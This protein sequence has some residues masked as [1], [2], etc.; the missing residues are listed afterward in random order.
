MIKYKYVTIWDGMEAISIC[1]DDTCKAIIDA[2]AYFGEGWENEAK[3]F[4]ITND[5]NKLASRVMERNKF[6]DI[7]LSTSEKDIRDQ[8]QFLGEEGRAEIEDSITFMG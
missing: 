5:P 1:S 3:D 8:F 6:F 7:V 4:N 2:L